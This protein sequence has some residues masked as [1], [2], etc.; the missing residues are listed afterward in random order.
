VDARDADTRDQLHGSTD[1]STTPARSL[2]TPTLGA[3]PAAA[4]HAAR[5][6]AR[7]RGLLPDA[8]EALSYG[9]PAFVVGGQPVAGYAWV[10]RQALHSTR[11]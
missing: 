11:C 1:G 3:A 6:R 5:V 8:D 7:L 4:D 9:I 2:V 10:R